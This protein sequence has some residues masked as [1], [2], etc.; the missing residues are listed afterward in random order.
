MSGRPLIFSSESYWKRGNTN[1]SM[2]RKREENGSFQF[3]ESN[4]FFVHHN[5][6]FAVGNLY[7]T[8]SSESEIDALRK[9]ALE[10]TTADLVP[11]I[12][13]ICVLLN[14][15]DIPFSRVVGTIPTVFRVQNIF[16][17]AVLVRFE[18]D[19]FLTSV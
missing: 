17:A 6:S 4:L 1:Q 11:C 16:S 15:L 18:N 3:Y 7:E 8:S 19:E 5:R 12:M 9:K 14:N 2:M 13:N 10:N